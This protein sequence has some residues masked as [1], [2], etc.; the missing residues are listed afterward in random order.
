MWCYFCFGLVFC[1]VL[2]CVLFG[3]VLLL[4]CY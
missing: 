1:V 2:V 4:V 3:S